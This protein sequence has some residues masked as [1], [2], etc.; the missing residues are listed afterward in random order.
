MVNVSVATSAP[1]WAASRVSTSWPLRAPANGSG[2]VAPW[3]SARSMTTTPDGPVA[4][5]MFFL[6]LSAHHP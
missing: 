5:Q 6:E 1:A 2:A 4:I 3:L